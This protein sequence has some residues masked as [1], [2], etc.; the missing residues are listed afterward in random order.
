LVTTL[1]YYHRNTARINLNHTVNFGK[2][3]QGS[4]SCKF[5]YISL[6]YLDGPDLENLLLSSTDTTIK[7]YWLIPITKEEKDFSIQNGS[8]S[9]EE[10][11]DNGF[12]Y[13]NPLRNSV[14]G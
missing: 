1:A 6:P 5:G 9:L 12:N 4:S 11:F 7:F 14:V 8:D 13:V 10:K 2:P 3:W